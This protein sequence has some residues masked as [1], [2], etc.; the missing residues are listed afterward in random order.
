MPEFYTLTLVGNQPRSNGGRCEIR[1]HACFGTRTSKL[2]I[3]W[4]SFRC[5]VLRAALV[6]LNVTAQNGIVL[7][8]VPARQRPVRPAFSWK[9]CNWLVDNGS[10]RPA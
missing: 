6:Y 8:H 5:E 1:R 10:S 3:S 9:G 7:V 4:R 2:D